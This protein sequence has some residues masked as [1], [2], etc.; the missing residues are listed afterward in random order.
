MVVFSVIAM[1]CAGSLIFGIVAI[2]ALFKRK[3]SLPYF[4]LAILF[5][6]LGFYCLT[7]PELK[8]FP[9]LFSATF[10]GNYFAVIPLL[11][12]LLCI[13]RNTKYLNFTSAFILS[14]LLLGIDIFGIY[15]FDAKYHV[16]ELA[17]TSKSEFSQVYWQQKRDFY[18]PKYNALITSHPTLYLKDFRSFNIEAGI[19]YALFNNQETPRA[20]KRY[21]YSGDSMILL[22]FAGMIGLIKWSYDNYFNRP[23]FN[24]LFENSYAYSKEWDV[25][26]VNGQLVFNPRVDTT[27]EIA[28]NYARARGENVY[29]QLVYKVSVLPKSLD[30]YIYYLEGKYDKLYY[31]EFTLYLSEEFL[32]NHNI[33]IKLRDYLAGPIKE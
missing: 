26:L 6:L 22:H 25:F 33:P 8:E 24:K 27:D 13:P 32:K 3:K 16:M 10:W 14:I 31:P 29:R 18:A 11:I 20:F 19:Q 28:I 2:A 5:N 4:I 1:I 12:Y 9:Y 15:Q 7:T 23:V 21:D 30:Q 17:T